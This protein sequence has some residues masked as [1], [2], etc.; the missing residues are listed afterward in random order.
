MHFNS[1]E[2][3]TDAELPMTIMMHPYT[4]KPP[5]ISTASIM[6]V[7]STTKL[8][9]LSVPS[10]AELPVIFMTFRMFVV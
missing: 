2:P 10:E 5:V 1:K 4:V 9:L 3:L 8:K 7:I 6:F